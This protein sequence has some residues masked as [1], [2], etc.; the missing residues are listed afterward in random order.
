MTQVY[1]NSDLHLAHRRVIQFHD[2]FRAKCMD[3]ETIE[4]HD[5]KIFDLWNDRVTKRDIIYIL[6]DVGYDLD[7]LKKMPG[8]KRLMLGNHDKSHALD[9]L[10]VF[11]DIIGPVKYKKHWLSHF[12][13]H[14]SE[15]YGRPV[16]HGH[17][18][19]T[20][21]A[22]PRYI[23]V[24]VEMT[25]GRPINYQNILNGKFTTYDKVNKPFEDVIW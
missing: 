1:F 10:E 9:Y 22:D 18:H 13:T 3:V 5:E 8:R 21:I 11:D 24:S 7:R 16:I 23:N 25:R 15:L 6:G 4:Q 19:S 2:N 20:G 14:E 12:P 17:T